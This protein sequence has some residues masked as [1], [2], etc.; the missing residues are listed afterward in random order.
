MTG[1]KLAILV[2]L[3]VATLAIWFFSQPKERPLAT[4]AESSKAPAAATPAENPTGRHTTPASN[5]PTSSPSPGLPVGGRAPRLPGQPE[6][7]PYNPGVSS[8]LATPVPATTAPSAPAVE[9]DPSEVA[10]DL[11]Q[12]QTALRNFRTALGGNPVGNN[13]EITRALLGDN[14][15]QIKIPVPPGSSVNA[16]GELIDRWATPYFFHQ[17]SGTKTEIRSAGPDRE[18]W[19]PDD[20]LRK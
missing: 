1:R 20:L 4:R 16:A 3:A 9:A 6:R 19:T 7:S 17:L 5:A 14:L 11:E 13:A 15:K 10:A 8:A 2:A 18:M 12:I